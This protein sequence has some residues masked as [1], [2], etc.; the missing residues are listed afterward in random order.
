MR[1]LF[2]SILLALVDSL[3]TN[4][5]YTFTVNASWSGNCSGYTPQMNQLMGKYKSQAINGFPTRELCEQTRAMCHQELGHIEL[6]FYDVKTGRVIKREATNCKLNV[7]TTPCTGYPM[8]GSIGTLNTLGVSQGTSFYNNNTSNEI[9]NWSNDYAERMLAHNPDYA[10][11]S[12][13]ELSMGS[14]E[15]NR[16]RN[17]V[18]EKAFFHPIN[19]RNDET[20]VPYTDAISMAQTHILELAGMTSSELNEKLTVV[21]EYIT[22]EYNQRIL[23]LNRQLLICE[24][25]IEYAFINALCNKDLPENARKEYEAKIEK[26]KDELISKYGVSLEDIVRIQ[27]DSKSWITE[28]TKLLDDDRE[29][30]E[31]LDLNLITVLIANLTDHYTLK[32]LAK[33]K[34]NLESEKNALE[35]NYNYEINK[36]RNV[37]D[38][39][40]IQ[41]GKDHEGKVTYG[42][43][44]TERA[45]DV[46][47]WYGDNGK[48]VFTLFPEKFVDMFIEKDTKIEIK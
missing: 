20:L 32:E 23:E 3:S 10:N 44:T 9:Q 45:S 15:T 13:T 42:S 39:L 38:L 25:K 17:Q 5:Q 18:R 47:A 12:E 2:V 37:T 36:L 29:I 11:T 22:A 1:K 35:F 26:M 19:A 7:T 4:A 34:N 30:K 48:D 28:T 14:S 6:T 43:I 24:V 31:G 21:E 8:A 27:D 46:M 33:L 16:V 40:N 41:Q